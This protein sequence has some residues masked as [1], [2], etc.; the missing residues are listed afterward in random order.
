MSRTS[1]LWHL[2]SMD[3]ELD[4]KTKRARQVSDALANDP[5]VVDARAALEAEQ[6]KLSQSRA[7]LKDRELDASSLD[8][9]IKE[10]ESRLYGGHVTNPK[11]LDSLEKDLQMRKRN[12]S[13]MDDK[14]LALMDSVEQALRQVEESALALRKIE[15]TRAGDLE[16][17]TRE[18]ETLA[19]RL[20]ELD[21]QREQARAALD[22]DAL[23]QYDH[24]RRTKAGRAVAQVKN[25]SCNMCGVAVPSG[26]IHRV[27]AGDEIVLCSSCGRI[28]T[29]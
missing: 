9:R 10:L 16:H 13:D 3:R 2:Q 23:R 12:R 29:S 1:S 24:L 28:L 18:K 5:K 15:E 21:A 4:D 7:M 25:D 17:L 6:K 14:L 8:A 22:A 20:G 11:E 19:K 27:R 26:L